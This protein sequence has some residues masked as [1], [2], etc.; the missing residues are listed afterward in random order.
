MAVNLFMSSC[1]QLVHLA[2]DINIRHISTPAELSLVDFSPLSVLGAASLSI[3]QI[4]LYVHTGMV[5]PDLTLATLLRSLEVYEDI[6][7]SMKEGVL[8]VRAEETAPDC[9]SGYWD[10]TFPVEAIHLPD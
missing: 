1:R 5:P 10:L 2:I 7:R 6:V 3:P 8:V 9:V 4:D